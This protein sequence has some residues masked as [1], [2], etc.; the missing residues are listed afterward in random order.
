MRLLDCHIDNFGKLSDRDISFAKGCNVFL[1]DNAWGKSTLAAFIRVMFYGFE[2]DRSRSEIE[3]ERR[4]YTPWQMGTYGGSVRFEAGGRTYVLE[5]TFADR[6]KDD[7]CVLRDAETNRPVPGIDPERAGEYFFGVDSESFRRSVF[8]SQNDAA[9][10]GTGGINAKIGN[11]TDDTDDINNYGTADAKLKD[12]LTKMSPDRSTG[13]LYKQNAEI[14]RLRTD[15]LNE[16]AADRALRTLQEEQESD[17]AEQESLR[18]ELSGLRGQEKAAA[19]YEVR[20]QVKAQYARLNQAY[21][22]A[23]DEVRGL[24]ERYPQGVPEPKEIISIKSLLEEAEDLREELLA[25]RLSAAEEQEAE[26]LRLRF[27]EEPPATEAFDAAMDS[28]KQRENLKARMRELEQ[29]A[30]RSEAARAA[31]KAAVSRRRNLMLIL[32]GIAAAILGIV[33]IFLVHWLL[34]GVVILA[35]LFMVLIG[36]MFRERREPEGASDASVKLR[37]QYE[38]CRVNAER[39]EESFR[40]FL[41]RYGAPY[42]EENALEAVYE[43]KYDAQRYQTLRKKAA[44]AAAGGQ[45]SRLEANLHEVR[46]F[47]VKYGIDPSVNDNRLDDDLQALKE[48]AERFKRAENALRDARGEVA[49][50]EQNT[51]E[52]AEAQAAEDAP[53]EL[54]LAE[55]HS[56]ISWIDA[57][58][59]ELQSTAAIREGQ[60]RSAQERYQ[61]LQD[62]KAELAEKE[63]KVARDEAYY[64]ELMLTRKLLADAKDTL[65]SQFTRPVRARFDHYYSMLTGDSPE[66]VYLDADAKLTAKEYGQQRSTEALSTGMQDLLGICLRAAFADTMY[67][68]EKPFLVFDDPFV[69]LDSD[70]LEQGMAL[71]DEIANEYQVI[72]FTCHESRVPYAAD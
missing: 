28:W 56:R 34:G 49:E 13:S 33:L 7:L 6:K 17:E 9:T 1:E 30:E 61:D 54:S 16:E 5:K 35:G 31:Q 10:S 27:G 58:L 23:A 12:K 67:P 66:A 62:E 53:P 36:C 64:Q 43:L 40:A 72:Y 21:H 48:R 41:A 25:A 8:I 19:S 45:A 2:N 24:S 69:N 55:I 15:L 57:R 44:A 51:P 59:R 4:R 38:F 60:I 39:A 18:G 11:M 20:L 46:A 29:E 14:R 3:N 37:E 71:L 26:A 50:F 70:K 32:P 47:L 52:L 42:Q 22:K 65:S 68:E 63:E